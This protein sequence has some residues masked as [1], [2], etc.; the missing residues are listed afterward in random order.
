MAGAGAFLGGLLGGPVGL[1]AGGVVGS[2]AGYSATRGRF[3]SVPEAIRELPEWRRQA[4]AEHVQGIVD[5]LDEGDVVV[6]T[7]L[8][9]AAAAGGTR[10]M[11]E[12]AVLR[13][14]CSAAVDYVRTQIA[15][16]QRTN[17]DFLRT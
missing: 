1:L 10:A 2:A 17:P 4:L 11:A 5:Q 13:Q 9:V 16:E 3:V 15:E 7:Q 12:H 8:A 14:V 6:L